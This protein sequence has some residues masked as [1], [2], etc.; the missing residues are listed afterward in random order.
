MHK[1]RGIKPRSPETTRPAS[2]ADARPYSVASGSTEANRPR[3]PRS[4]NFTQPDTLANSVSSEPMPTF[5]PGL[6]RVPR[7]RMMIDPPVTNWPANAFTPSRCAL[8]SRPFVELPPPFLFAIA[9][10]SRNQLLASRNQ[11]LASRNQ[12]PAVSY[13]LPAFLCHRAACSASLDKDR[14][15]NRRLPPRI[16]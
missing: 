12:L 8:E 7:C 4:V 13:P 11:L 9:Q 16:T 6:I 5:G 15:R 14:A 2:R 1:D 10:S 3:P